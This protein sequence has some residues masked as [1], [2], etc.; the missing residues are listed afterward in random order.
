MDLDLNK[1]KKK[2]SRAEKAARRAA[3][4]SGVKWKGLPKEVRKSLVADARTARALAKAAKAAALDSPAPAAAVAPDAV[5]AKAVLGSAIN[6]D[7]ARG[8]LDAI[9][10]AL[11]NS[12]PGMSGFRP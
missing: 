5:M 8:A 4:A 3:R 6:L 10:R 1:P 7:D 12:R 2:R 9:R 11:G